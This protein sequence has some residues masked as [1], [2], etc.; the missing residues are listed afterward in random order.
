MQSHVPYVYLGSMTVASTSAERLRTSHVASIPS[1]DI[2]L[3]HRVTCTV[4][5]HD[6]AQQ[7][8]DVSC[9]RK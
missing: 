5:V 3:P 9:N 4:L 8:N 2:M 7:L 6:S 1:S